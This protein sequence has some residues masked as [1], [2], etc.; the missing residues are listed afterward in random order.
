[1][2]FEPK[3][4]C[5]AVGAVGFTFHKFELVV[6]KMLVRWEERIS[7]EIA[8]NQCQFESFGKG[9]RGSI[10]TFSAPDKNLVAIGKGFDGILNR[11]R[12]MYIFLFHIEWPACKHDVLS[13]TQWTAELVEEG[14]ECATTHDDGVPE[15]EPFEPLEIF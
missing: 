1:M 9:Q 7:L 11:G 2:G 14:L 5:C 8:F 15:C 6:Q 3:C 13:S 4:R 10:H 12:C